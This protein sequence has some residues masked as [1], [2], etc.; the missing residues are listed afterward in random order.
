M[1]PTELHE[2]VKRRAEA[3]GLPEDHPMIVA[4]NK[5]TE[6]ANGYYAE[7]QIVN[8]KQFMGCWARARRCWCEYTGEPLV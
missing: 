3:D 8:I 7:P 5:F 6:A 1:K 4:A 2:R